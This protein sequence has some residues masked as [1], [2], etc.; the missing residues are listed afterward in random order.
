MFDFP[1]TRNQRQPKRRE[2]CTAAVLAASLPVD[3]NVAGAHWTSVT[4]YD[5]GYNV[6]RDAT[7]GRVTVSAPGAELGEVISMT[8]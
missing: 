4:D 2:D 6:Y 3:P 5:S 7:S 8:R 1:V